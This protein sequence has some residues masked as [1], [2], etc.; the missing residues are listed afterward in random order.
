MSLLVKEYFIFTILCISIIFLPATIE[1]VKNFKLSLSKISVVI[2]GILLQI[3]AI[4]LAIL[5]GDYLILLLY[6][7]GAIAV[8]WV[9]ILD[10]Q[11]S[12]IEEMELQDIISQLPGHVFWKD[13]SGACRGSNEVH[14]RNFGANSLEEFVGKTAYDLFSKEFADAITTNDNEVIKSGKTKSV[15]EWSNTISGEDKLFLGYKVPIKN[16]QGKII[17][18]GGISL[19][20]TNAKQEVE[21]R[22]HM[23]ESIIAMMPGHVYWMDRSGR[24]LGCNENKAKAMGLSSCKE[25]IGKTNYDLSISSMADGLEQINA[26]VM[27]SK[28]TVMSEEKG[29]TPEGEN[30]DFLSIKSPLFDSRNNVVGLVGISIDITDRKQKEQLQVENEA[31]K[32]NIQEHKIFTKLISQAVHDIRSPLSTLST[33]TQIPGELAKEEARIT[34]RNVRNKIAEIANSLLKQFKTKDLESYFTKEHKTPVPIVLVLQQL[35]IEKKIECTDLDIQFETNLDDVSG[36]L[37]VRMQPLSFQ[38]MISNLVNNSIDVFRDNK[39]GVITLNVET[40]ED[41]QVLIKIK[42]NGSGIPP[43]VLEKLRQNHT[44]SHGKEDGHGIGYTQIWDTLARNNGKIDIDSVEGHGTCVTVKFKLDRIPDWVCTN[45]NLNPDDIVLILD[46]DQ[47][48]HG[49]WDRYLTQYVNQDIAQIKHFNDGAETLRFINQLSHEDK[50]RVLFLCDYELLAQENTGLDLIRKS[51]MARSILVTSYFDDESIINRVSSM[52]IKLLPKQLVAQIDINLN[53]VKQE[54]MHDFVHMV[55][56]GSNV[57]YLQELKSTLPLDTKVHIYTKPDHLLDSLLKYPYD[58]KIVL[59]QPIKDA[60][61]TFNKLRD[62]GFS[63]IYLLAQPD[64]S[65]LQVPNYLKLIEPSSLG[66]ILY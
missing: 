32:Q 28:K 20:I 47:S 66:T 27:D 22:M 44:V 55:L 54:I 65:I 23:F 12:S 41:N 60:E 8:T 19:D 10:K 16:N 35:L 1:S 40:Q 26:E 57:S 24:Y 49:V 61:S 53:Q 7:V 62:L 42:D 11:V 50:H 18:L 56:F 31:N 6:I 17:G 46:D 33:I 64:Q 58:L 45:I 59:N 14:W 48:I 43:K 29:M 4:S 34:L 15:E 2:G 51:H 9:C 25:I 5:Y 52:G 3:I 21:D 36:F 37:F 38:R 13:L 63:N 30:A 39:S